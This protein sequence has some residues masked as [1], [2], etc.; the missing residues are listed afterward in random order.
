MDSTA[1]S[2]HIIAHLGAINEVLPGEV[3]IPDPAL[4]GFIF[5]DDTVVFP[6]YLTIHHDIM[7]AILAGLI[8]QVRLACVRAEHQPGKGP[9]SFGDGIRFLFDAVE[10]HHA[11]FTSR[12]HESMVLAILAEKRSAL[13]NGVVHP[14]QSLSI[15]IDLPLFRLRV[16]THNKNVVTIGAD[17][18]CRGHNVADPSDHGSLG[19]RR[20]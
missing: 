19:R 17:P 6:K 10:N 8:G 5:N 4:R 14:R 3:K 7:P 16:N 12:A 1:T 18:N 15:V 20:K 9:A 11:L 2:D 13:S